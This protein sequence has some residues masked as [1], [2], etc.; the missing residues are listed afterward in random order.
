MRKKR[1]DIGKKA[2]TMF[3]KNAIINEIAWNNEHE[4]YEGSLCLS[5]SMS[6]NYVFHFYG[7]YSVTSGI[8]E[9]I[10]SLDISI[11]EVC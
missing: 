9:I 3:A 7:T 6:M 8:K 10:I 2:L 5:M 4:Y 11:N 1:F